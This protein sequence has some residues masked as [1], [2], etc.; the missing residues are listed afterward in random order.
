[1]SHTPTPWNI[2]WAGGEAKEDRHYMIL[3][4]HAPT[5]DSENRIASIGIGSDDAEADAE[6]IVNSRTVRGAG[7]S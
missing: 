3:R 5:I 7:R 1:M 2:G 6:F 4:R